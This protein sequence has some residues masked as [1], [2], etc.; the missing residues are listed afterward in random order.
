MFFVACN[1]KAAEVSEV[2]V[3]KEAKNLSMKSIAAA[4]LG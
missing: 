3:E 1:R 4:K 2:E